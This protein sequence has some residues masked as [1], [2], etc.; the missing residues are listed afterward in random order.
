MEGWAFIPVMMPGRPAGR[1]I[2]SNIDPEDDD[3]D[4][5]D[6][7]E[8]GLAALEA[9]RQEAPLFLQLDLLGSLQGGFQ[10]C[11]IQFGTPNRS[12]E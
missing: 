2:W 6:L 4:N 10:Q 9:A 11:K 3:L 8:P 1:W 5:P 12:F 7:V